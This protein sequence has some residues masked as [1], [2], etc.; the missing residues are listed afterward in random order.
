EY[1]PVTPGVA[2]SS[3]VRC[4]TFDSSSLNGL[5]HCQKGDLRVAFLLCVEKS[6]RPVGVGPMRHES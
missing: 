6:A 2:G 3:P 4:A 1:R 5:N